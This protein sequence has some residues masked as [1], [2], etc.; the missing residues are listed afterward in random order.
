MSALS[1]MTLVPALALASPSIAGPTIDSE[2]PR[3]V[4][5]GKRIELLLQDYNEIFKRQAEAYATFL[6]IRPTL[7]E[8]L[9]VSREN[10][11]FI[12]SCAVDE[13]D[14]ISSSAVNNPRRILDSK[15]LRDQNHRIELR[16]KMSSKL[17]REVRRLTRLATQYEKTLQAALAE[18]RYP[19]IEQEMRRVALD[20]EQV[21]Y[22]LRDVHIHTMEGVL[23]LAR[24]LSTFEKAE[25][26]AGKL[27]GGSAQ[28][29]GS[30]L[31]EA[32]LRISG[33]EFAVA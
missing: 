18:S 15:L 2:D 12:R 25:V 13:S 27:I 4:E 32:F 1:S 10:H 19:V 5:L 11:L 31:A 17:R 9:V 21:A 20:L 28:I 26:S 6:R 22:A 16:I 3:A 24:T 33:R 23:I 14:L 29:L 7:P 30:K 8:Q